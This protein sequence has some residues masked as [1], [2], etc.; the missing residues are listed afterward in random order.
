MNIKNIHSVYFIGIGGIGMS[1]IARWFHQNGVKVA[2]YDK[3]PSPLTQKLQDE[4]IEVSFD[5]SVSALPAFVKE[6]SDEVV[7]VYTPAIPARHEA[8]SYLKE[9]GRKLYKRSQVLGEITKGLPT[10]AVAGTHGKTTTSSMIAHIL[11]QGGMNIAGFLGGI[12]TNYETNM[13]INEGELETATVVVEADEF[14]R[15]F[16]TLH[17]NVAIVTSTDADHLDIYGEAEAL[18]ESFSAFMEKVSADGKIF[19]KEGLWS[20]LSV[21]AVKADYTAYGIEEGK[22]QAVDIKIEDGVFKFDVKGP[23][24]ELDSLE[25]LVPGYHNVENATAAIA[26]AYEVG[27][28]LEEIKKGIASYR[29]VKRRFEYIIKA[30]EFAYIDDYAHHPSE[31][32]AMLRSV[33][34]LYPEQKITVLFQPHLYS[35]TRDFAD[36]FAESLSMADELLLMDIYPAREEPIPGVT[37]EMLLD[38]AKVENKK[39]LKANEVVDYVQDRA[40]EVFI[41]LGAGDID[42]LVQPL[43]NAF[44]KK[45]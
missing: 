32:F 8:F 40:F 18:K 17:P 35:R 10:I 34:A 6:E 13:L 44:E 9:S 7:I 11:K 26:A 4:G 19:I 23:D 33:R 22:V 38:K 31:I 39:L 12:S 21:G 15:S 42:R 1:A 30:K 37:S 14:D 29:G 24:F 41:T 36:G 27:L 2:G 43:K 28:P 45:I 3:T 25:L 20:G 5:E 16:L